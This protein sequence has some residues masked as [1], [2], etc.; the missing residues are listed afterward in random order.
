MSF[1]DSIDE[2]VE[3]RIEF[4]QAVENAGGRE[5]LSNSRYRQT[6]RST[7]I[8]FEA[9]KQ[10]SLYPSAIVYVFGKTYTIAKSIKDRLMQVSKEF[11]VP[12]NIIIAQQVDK[13]IKNIEG[14]GR[15]LR[16]NGLIKIAEEC[17]G[18]SIC[19]YDHTC[20]E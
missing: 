19:V 6:G 7:R 18:E 1:Y 12:Y 14:E 2:Y 5:C 9:L 4:L 16:I 20:F 11:N 10:M 15:F 8:I 3:K 17:N 13:N